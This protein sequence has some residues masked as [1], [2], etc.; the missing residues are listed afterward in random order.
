LIH[1]YKRPAE[2]QSLESPRLDWGARGELL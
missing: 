1:F 2:D